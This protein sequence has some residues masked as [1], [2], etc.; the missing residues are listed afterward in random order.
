MVDRA[1]GLPREFHSGFEN[2]AAAWIV[3]FGQHINHTQHASKEELM[4]KP[5]WKAKS[6]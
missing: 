3:V 4:I 6:S 1:E 5:H 2:P